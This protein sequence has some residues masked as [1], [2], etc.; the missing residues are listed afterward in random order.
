MQKPDFQYYL[1][2][3]HYKYFLYPQRSFSDDDPLKSRNDIMDVS[4]IIPHPLYFDKSFHH[5]ATQPGLISS[6][7][8]T[9]YM[10]DLDIK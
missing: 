4:G 7:L 1:I 6:H 8:K 3:V 5:R 2:T 9:Q 10:T